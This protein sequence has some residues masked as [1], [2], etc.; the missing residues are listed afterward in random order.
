MLQLAAD[1]RV[2]LRQIQKLIGQRRSRQAMQKFTQR[3][4]AIL[5]RLHTFSA[6]LNFLTR[7]LV[8]RRIRL[9]GQPRTPDQR[10]RDLVLAEPSVFPVGAITTTCHFLVVDPHF[11]RVVRGARHPCMNA[12]S[13]SLL[14]RNDLHRAGRCV[15]LTALVDSSASHP[16]ER[17]VG[18]QVEH[19]RPCSAG[20]RL[21]A[22]VHVIRLNL[23]YAGTPCAMRHFS[24][25]AFKGPE[26]WLSLR[27]LGGLYGRLTKSPQ[28]RIPPYTVS[29]RN[30]RL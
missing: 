2:L 13:G 20:A 27:T 18:E 19:G 12:G 4:P 23:P 14:L 8:N 5:N 16:Q 6:G 29:A 11:G 17:G 22:I 25:V 3:R 24:S 21:A 1:L 7:G 9:P 10:N 26:Q 15:G 30:A 28:P